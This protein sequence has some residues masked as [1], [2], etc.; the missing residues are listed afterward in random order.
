GLGIFFLDDGP[1]I[2]VSV[3]EGQ[4]REGEG[5]P[6]A[7]VQLAQIILDESI[8]GDRGGDGNGALD[9][10]GHLSPDPTGNLPIGE[11]PSA[12]EEGGPQNQLAALFNVVKDGGADGEKSTTYAYGFALSSGGE[13]GGVETTLKVTDPNHTYSNDTIY[14]FKVS[15]TEI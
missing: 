1:T 9:D 8:G 7:E 10:T 2:T 11:L 13:Q 15:D 4:P 14:L 3:A 12:G 5:G 6:H